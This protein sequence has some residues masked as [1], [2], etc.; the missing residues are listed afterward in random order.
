MFDYRWFKVGAYIF[1]DPKIKIIEA[2][3]DSD[4][5]ICIW[6]KSLSLAGIVNDS[7]YLYINEETPYT[8]KTLAIEFN[9]PFEKVKASMKVLRKLQM[10]E[11]TE[12]K[13]YRVKNWTKYQNVDALEK[14]RTET[15]KRVA[16]H[17]AKKKLEKENPNDNA[18]GKNADGVEEKSEK[19]NGSENKVKESDENKDGSDISSSYENN[20]RIQIKEEIVEQENTNENSSK[21]KNDNGNVTSNNDEVKE[22]VTCN[23]Y[24]SQCN[25]NNIKGNVIKENI[26]NDSVTENNVTVTDKIKRETKSKTKTE[27]KNE[28][29]IKKELSFNLSELCANITKYYE[30]IT[31]KVGCL[32]YGKLRLVLTIH[33]EEYVKMAINKAIESGKCDFNYINGILKNWK[34]EGYPNDKEEVKVSGGKRNFK[35]NTADKNEF[36][37][38]KPKKPKQL[39]EEQRKKIE[40]DLI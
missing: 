40:A 15:S 16:K 10:I 24:N 29:E 17:R 9:R 5:I 36:A 32:D 20:K 35:G 37:G 11:F 31:G 6:F 1:N 19:I 8:L 7:G 33:G 30:S 26:C 38:F 28:S 3:D 14:Q 25:I 34:R 22:D 13:F 2:E 12:D 27:K 18:N 23:E 4:T 39:T 21:S